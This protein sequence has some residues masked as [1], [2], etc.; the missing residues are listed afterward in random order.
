VQ[1]GLCFGPDGTPVVMIVPTWCG[2]PEEGEGRLA[3][4]FQLG[5][6]LAGTVEATPYGT[7]LSVFD[8]FFVNGQ[9]V[10][11]ETCWLPALDGRS[12]DTLIEAMTIAV[13]PG[14]A[15][16]VHEFRGAASREPAEATAFGLRHDHVLIEIL[17]IFGDRSDPLEEQRHRQ[18]AEATRHAL[19]AMALPGGYPNLLGGDDA[20]RAAKS[21]G[22]NAERLI[23]AKHRYDPDNIFAS[24]IPLPLSLNLEG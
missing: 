7:S 1:P 6:L 10:F 2:L 19:D 16:L 11:M 3:P 20:D 21:Y 23:R 13:S 18:W 4:F 22:C 12:I 17:A 15:I 9:R 8:P 5:T 24:T 14:C